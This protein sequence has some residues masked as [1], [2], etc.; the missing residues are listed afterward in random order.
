[1]YP[2]PAGA[3]LDGYPLYR[4]LPVSRSVVLAVGRSRC[5]VTL[6]RG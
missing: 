1:V 3:V 2:P 5:R 6:G 4:A